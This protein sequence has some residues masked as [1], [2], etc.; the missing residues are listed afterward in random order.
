MNPR[1]VFLLTERVEVIHDRLLKR[2]GKDY[3]LALLS[4]MAAKEQE[5]AERFSEQYD[6]PLIILQPGEYNK[7]DTVVKEFGEE[8][9]N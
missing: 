9:L 4:E 5:L 7:I 6:V 2:D 8:Y 1:K 3:D